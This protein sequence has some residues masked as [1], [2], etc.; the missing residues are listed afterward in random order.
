MPYCGRYGRLWRAFTARRRVEAAG[1]AA[2]LTAAVLVAPGIAAAASASPALSFSP[3]PFNY[4]QVIVRQPASQTFSLANSGRSATGRLTVTLTGSAAFTITGNTCKSLAPGKTCRVTVRFTPV[5]SGTVTAT[6]TVAGKKHAA[7]AVDALTGT[8]KGLGQ[9]LGSIYWADAGDGTINAAGFG[10][11]TSQQLIQDQNMP[12]GVAMNSTHLYWTSNFDGTINE[13]NLDGSN[14]QTLIPGQDGPTGLAADGSHIYWSS[15]FDGTISEANLDG[16]NAHVIVAQQT[17]PYGVAV[18]G[19]HLYWANA[20]PAA[21]QIGTINEA[22]LDGTNPR[23]IVPSQTDPS[24]PDQIDPSG[25]A[26]DGSHLFWTDNAA[27]AAG[28]ARSGRPISTAPARMPSPSTRTGRSGWR[29]TAATSTGP[30]SLTRQSN[31]PTRMAAARRPSS[32][33]WAT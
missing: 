28:A 10:S 21:S 22:N 7:H 17:D 33:A 9:D 25:V 2:M 12:V 6:L 15:S 8:G 32:P 4:G 16:S 18:N 14:P 5:T 24:V 31:R 3:A 26:A 23:V 1:A 27:D 29:P 30:T 11:S 20:G 13:A 19:S